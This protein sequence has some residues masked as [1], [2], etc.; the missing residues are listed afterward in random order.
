MSH[1]ASLLL[2][3]FLQRDVV[4]YSKYG[5]TE[6]PTMGTNETRMHGTSKYAIRRQHS[7]IYNYRTD[8]HG[9]RTKQSS[10]TRAMM[11]MMM[12]MLLMMMMMMM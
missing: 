1:N 5:P 2:D 4:V 12:M 6:K 7:R 10:Y 11:M 3:M 9:N 8:M